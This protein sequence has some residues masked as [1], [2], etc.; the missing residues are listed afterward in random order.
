MSSD[1]SWAKC[2]PTSGF[3]LLLLLLLLLLSVVFLVQFLGLTNVFRTQ[4]SLANRCLPS[5]VL[6]GQQISSW[7][8]W[9][10]NVFTVQFIWPTVFLVQFVGLTNVFLV[11]FSRANEY[12]PSS[13]F[14]G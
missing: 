4:F 8:V 12:L 13:V 1:F 2:L 11:P 5:S 9:L 6:F 7:F 3:L 10:T 14:L